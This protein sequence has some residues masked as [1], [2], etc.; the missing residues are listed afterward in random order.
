MFAEL[1]FMG[2]DGQ[3]LLPRQWCLPVLPLSM[4]PQCPQGRLRIK[5]LLLGPWTR[6]TLQILG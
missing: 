5:A 4:A 3:T 6:Q 2:R 1:K